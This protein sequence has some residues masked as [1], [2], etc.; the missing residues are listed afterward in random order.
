[1]IS[2]ISG[3]FEHTLGHCWCHFLHCVTR[4]FDEIARPFA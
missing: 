4:F 3:D 1:M 2:E